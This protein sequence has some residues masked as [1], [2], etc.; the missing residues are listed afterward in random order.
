MKKYIIAVP[1]LLVL[2]IYIWYRTEAVETQPLTDEIRNG[3][4]GSFID[5][6]EGIVHFELTGPEEG[7]TAVLIH[8]FS[9]PHY[10]WDTT[11]EFLAGEGYR[12]LRYD[13]YGRGYSDRPDAVYDAGLFDRQLVSLLQGLEITEPVH[14]FGLSMGGAIAVNFAA[15][16]PELVQK[17]ILVDPSFP[18]GAANS[19]LAM[20]VV[21]EFLFRVSNL[22][23]MAEGQSADFYR[24]EKYPDWPERFRIQMQYRGF[25]R[26]ILSTIRHF[27]TKDFSAEYETVGG[28]GIPA[29][30][31]WGEA[32]NTISEGTIS[33]IREKI[34]GIVFHAIP[35]AG[36]IP[37]YERPDLVN[38]LISA[39]IQEK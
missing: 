21:G 1:L 12:V 18:K 5:L 36:H 8:G 15:N 4:E 26:A 24:P 39:F 29:M 38:P 25:E 27:F 7:Q 37:H 16:H 19:T 6:P 14:L 3:A 11:F 33:E 2:C 23:G 13:L 20:P 30:L 17:L 34:P 28:S 35:E 10:I 22:G 32:D 31:L 9:V